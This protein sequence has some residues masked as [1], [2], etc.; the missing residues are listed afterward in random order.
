MS[1]NLNSE[2]MGTR[3]FDTLHCFNLDSQYH[4]AGARLH[5]AEFSQSY[6][7]L[8]TYTVY[9]QLDQTQATEGRARALEI[10]KLFGSGLLWNDTSTN[11]IKYH[12]R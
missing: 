9:I 7:Y 2:A 12:Q 8:Y 3:S 4:L 5:R 11:I 6:I 10:V 1:P